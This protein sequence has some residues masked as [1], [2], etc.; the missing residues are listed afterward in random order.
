[1]QKKT[2]MLIAAAVTTTTL[3]VPGVALAGGDKVQELRPD[4]TAYFG[5][6]LQAEGDPAVSE[7]CFEFG[8]E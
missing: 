2:V 3:L 5:D 1:M 8:Q 4:E 6:A 7:R